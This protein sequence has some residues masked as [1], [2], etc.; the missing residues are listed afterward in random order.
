MHHELSIHRASCPHTTPPPQASTMLPR[1][2]ATTREGGGAKNG[3]KKCLRFAELKVN[4]KSKPEYKEGGAK[5]CAWCGGTCKLRRFQDFNQSGT[6]MLEST[7][8]TANQ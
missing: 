6:C 4:L 3:G 5:S 1:N 8:A 2:R 7:D